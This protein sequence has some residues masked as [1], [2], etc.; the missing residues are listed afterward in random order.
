[1]TWEYQNLQEDDGRP[2]RHWSNGRV[3]LRRAGNW[4]ERRAGTLR[5]EWTAGP[6]AHCGWGITLGGGDSGSD[7]GCNASV[8]FLLAVYVTLE[9]ALPLYAFGTDFD[10]GMDR[11]IGCYFYAWAFW[12]Q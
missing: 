5:I 8:P 6:H 7:V 11:Q 2:R 10:R 4:Y 9:R 12:Y 1:M 3:W